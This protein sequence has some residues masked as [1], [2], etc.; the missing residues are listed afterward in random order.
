MQYILDVSFNF[1]S[2]VSGASSGPELSSK[3]PYSEITANMIASFAFK[4]TFSKL[5]MFWTGVME[6]HFTYISEV[7]FRQRR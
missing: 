5:E 3:F 7:N 4:A 6:V 2:A 1:P